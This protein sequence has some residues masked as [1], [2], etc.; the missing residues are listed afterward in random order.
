MVKHGLSFTVVCIGWIFMTGLI[1]QDRKLLG[2]IDLTDICSRIRDHD[3][4][5][6]FRPRGAGNPQLTSGKSTGWVQTCSLKGLGSD[7]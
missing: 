6:N 5:M 1:L 4:I 7:K 3:Q 2:Q